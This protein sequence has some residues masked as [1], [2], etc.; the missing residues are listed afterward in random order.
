MIQSTSHHLF[1][2]YNSIT[3]LRHNRQFAALNRR[4]LEETTSNWT[5][6]NLACEAIDDFMVDISGGTFAYDGTI[7]PRDWETLWSCT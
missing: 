5:E 6:G 1:T 3:D 2:R 4:C 7:F